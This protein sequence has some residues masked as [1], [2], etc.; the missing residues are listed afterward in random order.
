M[1]FVNIKAIH[2]IGL[3]HVL[4][5]DYKPYHILRDFTLGQILFS[6]TTPIQNLLKNLHHTKFKVNAEDFPLKRDQNLT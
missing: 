6:A 2:T 4:N 5:V 1:K 3:A